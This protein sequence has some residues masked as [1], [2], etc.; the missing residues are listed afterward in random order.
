MQWSP[1]TLQL[2]CPYPHIACELQCAYPVLTQAS[3]ANRLELQCAYLRGS[4]EGLWPSLP[5]M[6]SNPCRF[7][8]ACL[9]SP[10][11][12]AAAGYNGEQKAVEACSVLASAPSHLTQPRVAAV[13]V[14]AGVP[15]SSG[16]G[17]PELSQGLLRALLEGFLALG[18]GRWTR[19]ARGPASR[20]PE[21]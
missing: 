16:F 2:Q 13:T 21:P 5:I 12:F 18:R 8:A 15:N 9:A 3:L 10:I 19:A 11:Y 4:N 20:S 17:G 7:A 6:R 1:L 14:L